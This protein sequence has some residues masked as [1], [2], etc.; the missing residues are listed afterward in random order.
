[1]LWCCEFVMIF[2][3][4]FSN[5][6]KEKI[7]II[8]E[9][10]WSKMSFFILHCALDSTADTFS[11]WNSVEVLD[12]WQP[13][14][15]S[16]MGCLFFKTSLKSAD[17]VEKLV[18][19][20]VTKPSRRTCSPLKIGRNLQKCVSLPSTILQRWAVS[21]RECSLSGKNLIYHLESRWRT[22]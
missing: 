21:F 19:R 2:T 9:S 17:C 1:M 7:K 3:M 13:A 5:R 20:M 12:I 14:H 22:S 4:I 16:M 6:I 18:K 8:V 10:C 11:R 15:G